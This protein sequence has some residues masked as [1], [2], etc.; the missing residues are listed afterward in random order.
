MANL[1]ASSHSR[2]CGGNPAGAPGIKSGLNDI[3]F[4]YAF[5][6]SARSA[7]AAPRAFPA[8]Y[9][10]RAVLD[11]AQPA[12]PLF[13][14]LQTRFDEDRHEGRNSCAWVLT[15]IAAFRPQCGTPTMWSPARSTL[16]Q[17]VSVRDLSP[18]RTFMRL[19]AA[20]SGQMVNVSALAG[21][22]VT[23]QPQLKQLPLAKRASMAGPKAQ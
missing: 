23:G 14:Y 21:D 17:R 22:C 15:G 12:P 3:A 7:L 6:V 2:S 16:R 18:F 5:N 11:E 9:P 13:S 4:D 10:D 20:R 19:R 1:Q 8:L